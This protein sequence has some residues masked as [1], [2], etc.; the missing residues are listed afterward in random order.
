M[1]ASCCLNALTNA[2]RFLCRLVHDFPDIPCAEVPDTCIPNCVQTDGFKS[3][4]IVPT[5]FRLLPELLLFLHMMSLVLIIGLPNKAT[6]AIILQKLE[7]LVCR[8]HDILSQPMTALQSPVAAD[9]TSHIGIQLSFPQNP[10]AQQPVYASQPATA[11][12]N[13]DTA[14][15]AASHSSASTS[16]LN[17]SPE[18]LNTPEPADM[19]AAVHSKAPQVNTAMGHAKT[20]HHVTFSEARQPS[21]APDKA[22]DSA[23]ATWTIIHSDGSCS[24]PASRAASVISLVRVKSEV[25]SGH[26]ADVLR[27][28]SAADEKGTP[29]GCQGTAAPCV[30]KKLVVQ[31]PKT[32]MQLLCLWDSYKSCWLC[33]SHGSTCKSNRG[34]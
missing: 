25:P 26:D 28:L 7:V 3:V 31:V 18:E 19:I 30:K 11:F 13:N 12:A 16:A 22:S 2:V 27:T 6:V 17:H 9:A 20:H 5:S 32:G 33:M 10:A 8:V 1:P 14:P 23:D 29:S 15:A 34:S 21:H 4:R 24:Q